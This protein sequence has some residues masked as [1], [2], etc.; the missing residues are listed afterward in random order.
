MK[1]YN[2]YRIGAMSGGTHFVQQFDTMEAAKK[3]GES[4]ID[5]QVFCGFEIV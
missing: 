2:L 3:A 4:L 5:N 1:K